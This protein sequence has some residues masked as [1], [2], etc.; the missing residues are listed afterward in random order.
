MEID[1]ERT[2]DFQCEVCDHWLALNC[3]LHHLTSMVQPTGHTGMGQTGMGPTGMGQT[4]MG[5]V[6]TFP[7]VGWGILCKCFPWSHTALTAADPDF[8]E[9]IQ[10]VGKLIEKLAYTKGIP[11]VYTSCVYWKLV[12]YQNVILGSSETGNAM[13][14]HGKKTWQEKA[15]YFRK[16]TQLAQEWTTARMCWC[17]ADYVTSVDVHHRLDDGCVCHG[18]ICEDTLQQT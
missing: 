11:F 9:I 12:A 1:H 4:G 14:A 15:I 17:V 5:Q 8:F 16:S 2:Q 13:L 7:C 10:F 6:V 18:P 3:A